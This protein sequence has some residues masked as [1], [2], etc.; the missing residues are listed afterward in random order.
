MKRSWIVFGL[1]TLAATCVSMALQC[2]ADGKSEE[3]L[4]GQQVKAELRTMLEEQDPLRF[5][6]LMSKFGRERFH[7]HM[8]IISKGGAYRKIRGDFEYTVRK[9]RI[10]I[11]EQGGPA[12]NPEDGF[13]EDSTV[14]VKARAPV[15]MSFCKDGTW[16]SEVFKKR[17]LQDVLVFSYPH[18]VQIDFENEICHWRELEEK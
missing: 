18:V 4:W 2:F 12:E 6:L 8:P 5:A 1:G 15:V 14:L 10:T 11:L 3:K 7:A 9:R 16:N 17:E 13:F